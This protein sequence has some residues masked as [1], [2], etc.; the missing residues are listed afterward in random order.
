MEVPN[1]FNREKYF[2]SLKKEDVAAFVF[3]SKNF[4]P[5]LNVLDELDKRGYN[6]KIFQFTIT[7]HNH[8]WMEPNIP[9][10]SDTIEDFIKLSKRY[11]KDVMFW[12]YDPVVFTDSLDIEDEKNRFASIAQRLAQHT[13]SCIFSIAQFYKKVMRSAGR[14]EEDRGI[15]MFDPNVEIKREYASHLLQCAKDF[16]LKLQACCCDYLLDIPGIGQAHCIDGELI[17]RMWYPDNSFKLQPSRKGC[18]CAESSDIGVYGTCKSDCIYC[19]A[20]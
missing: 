6:K 11:G 19:Y 15:S 10:S 16:G 14:L 5:F 18:G 17:S 20:R 4:R 7:G 9:D 13:D 8:D 12:R 2:V 1:P 3:W